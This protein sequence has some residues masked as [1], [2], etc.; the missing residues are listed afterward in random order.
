MKNLKETILEKLVITKDTR[1][2][3]S[4]DGISFD[5]LINTFHRYL[6]KH[7]NKKGVTG[8]LNVAA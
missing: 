5:N 4:G 3:R 8:I 6:E 1:E 2:K 7:Y